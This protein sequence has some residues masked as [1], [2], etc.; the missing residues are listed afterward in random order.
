MQ[1]QGNQMD[2]QINL[3]DA[4]SCL[5]GNLDGPP[6]QTAQPDVKTP[7]RRSLK[8]ERITTINLTASTCRWP[9]GDPTEPDFHYCGRQS[10]TNGPYCDTHEAMSR[11]P[12]Q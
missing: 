3:T 12:G 8:K 6:M 9:F 4:T 10:Q 1:K 7:I 5:H 2:E 11:P